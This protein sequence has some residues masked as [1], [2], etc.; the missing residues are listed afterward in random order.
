MDKRLTPFYRNLLIEYA[1]HNMS[2]C[3]TAKDMHYA[4]STIT[5]HLDQIK[6]LTGKDPRYFFDLA[7]LLGMKGGDFR[8]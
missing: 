8:G 1:S 7:E 4:Y 5:Y 2:S 3:K 6:Q